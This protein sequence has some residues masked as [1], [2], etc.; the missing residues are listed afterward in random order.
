[1]TISEQTNAR[2]GAAGVGLPTDLDA[3]TVLGLLVGALQHCTAL[4]FDASGT[5]VWCCHRCPGFLGCTNADQVVGSSLCR[6]TPDLWAA[7]R[8]AAIARAVREQR[9]ITLL[10]IQDGRRMATRCI[11]VPGRGGEAERVLAVTE[12]VEAADVE[13]LSETEGDALVWSVVHD[14]GP[15]DALTAR[16]L[17]V[18][19]L[20]GQGKRTKEIAETVHRSVSTIDGHRERIG[21]KL[22]LNDRAELITVARRACLRAEDAGGT[23]VRL[24]KSARS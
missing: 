15:L 1:M 18:L 6:F 24:R 5:I 19:A 10:S 4:I 23:R 2:H 21:Q 16:E 14:L 13:R 8:I 17:E 22:D 3:E 12:P 7:E 11:P 20:L 9:R